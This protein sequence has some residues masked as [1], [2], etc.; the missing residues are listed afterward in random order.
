[1]QDRDHHALRRPLRLTVPALILIARAEWRARW[2]SLLLIGL[3]A[4]LAGAMA[5]G[6]TGLARRTATVDERLAVATNADDVRSLVVGGD[7]AATLAIGQEA[8]DLPGV[9]RG[10]VA[11]GTVGRVDGPDVVYISVL[12]GPEHWGRDVLS[13]VLSAGRL[14]RADRADEVVLN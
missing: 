4:G 10:R 8:L 1:V 9:A 5:A 11:L 12:V 3:L 13:P 2:S 6:A 14:P 7:R